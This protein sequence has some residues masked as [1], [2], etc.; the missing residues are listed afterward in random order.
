MAIQRRNYFRVGVFVALALVMIV[1][2]VIVLGGGAFLRKT[3]VMETYIEESVQGLDVGSA[4]RYR[5]VKVGTVKEIT[6]VGVAYALEPSDPRFFQV[7]QLVTVRMALDLASLRGGDASGEHLEAIMRRLVSNGL[8]VRLASQGITG[9]SYL[10]VDYLPPERNPPLQISWIPTYF[11]LP[12]APSTIS[13]LSSAAEQVFTRLEEANLEQVVTEATLLLRELRETNKK[14]QGLVDGA[15]VSKAVGDVAVA[16]ERV[17]AVAEAADENVG[18]ILVDLRET[19][20]RLS[21]LSAEVQQQLGGQTLRTIVQNVR[22]SVQDVRKAMAEL[23]EA[24]AAAG[25]A[26]RRADSL[27][28]EGQQ[29]FQILLQN[30]NQIAE[31]LKALTE[32]ARRYPSQLLFG[33]P[34][35]RSEP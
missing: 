25:R 12:S 31:N 28:A 3:V 21:N 10:E 9:T 1:V 29:D 20:L 17:R 35:A 16:A 33:Q 5:G 8:R 22:E 13:R 23:P 19:T 14:V 4:V 34:P 24:T 6:F 2:G 11:Y 26:A 27:I 7:G 18:N 30:L 32:N 15:D